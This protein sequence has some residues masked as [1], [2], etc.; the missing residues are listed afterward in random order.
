MQRILALQKVRLSFFHA[1]SGCDIV[2]AFKN[3][4]KKSFFQTWEV[5]PDITNTFLKLSSYPVDFNKT[6]EQLVE[7][8]ISILYDISS[9][10]FKVDNTRKKLFSQKNSTYDRQHPTH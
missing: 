4:G 7:K 9:K 1:L 3:K 6:D 2:S 5:F 10:S 8:F